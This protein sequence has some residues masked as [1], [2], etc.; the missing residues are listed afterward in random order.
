MKKITALFFSVVLLFSLPGSAKP[1]V[2][3]NTAISSVKQNGNIVDFTLTSAKPF[4]FGSNRYILTIGDKTFYLNKQWAA[5]GKG[6]LVFFIP[7]DDF[8]KLTEGSAIYLTYGD[9]PG[10]SSAQE[11][12]AMAKENGRCWPLGN[13]SKALLTK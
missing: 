4:I 6:T 1:Q 2:R 9:M 8:N 13:F 7:A 12:E 5:Q 10:N 11:K 3:P